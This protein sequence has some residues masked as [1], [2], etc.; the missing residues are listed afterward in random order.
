MLFGR[1]KFNGLVMYEERGHTGSVPDIIKLS[2][3]ENQHSKLMIL[4]YDNGARVVRL[5]GNLRKDDWDKRTQSVWISSHLKHSDQDHKSSNGDS[6]TE[7]KKDL[8]SYLSNF[9][10]PKWCE[11]LAKLDCSSVK[12]FFIGSVPECH[13][14]NSKQWGS[15]RLSH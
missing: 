6:E 13:S 11:Y 3:Q 14:E 12:M 9:N 7:F 4:K 10:V 15:K 2:S 1:A 5:T 8:I